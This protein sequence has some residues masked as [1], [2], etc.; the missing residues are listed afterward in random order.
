MPPRMSLKHFHIVFIVV[1]S[2]MCLW[3]VGWGWAHRAETLGAA[4]T[5]IGTTGFVSL[6]VYLRWFLRSNA[7]TA[8]GVHPKLALAAFALL[9]AAA[10]I[11]ACPTCTGTPDAPTARAF[12]YGILF[13][14]VLVLLTLSGITYMMVKAVRE[15]EEIERVA[16]LPR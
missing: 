12:A 11:Q 8:N 4:L 9:A 15:R 14:A 3:L 6:A 5:G 2:A 7:P 13:M 16:A 10:D 1:A